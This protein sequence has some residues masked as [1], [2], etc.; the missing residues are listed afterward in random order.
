[1]VQLQWKLI[2]MYDMPVLTSVFPSKTYLDTFER[3]QALINVPTS[4]IIVF[5]EISSNSEV[6]CLVYFPSA[7][8]LLVSL[9]L[10]KLDWWKWL[11][12]HQNLDTFIQY[13]WFSQNKFGFTFFNENVKEF[14]RNN[15]IF[16]LL[17]FFFGLPFVICLFSATCLE[18]NLWEFNYC[19]LFYSNICLSRV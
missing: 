2:Y 17:F 3:T 11:P 19:I 10:L 16:S 9:E 12:K 1:M 4:C 13:R 5:Y 14:L 15:C 18:I 8:L 7:R 6:F